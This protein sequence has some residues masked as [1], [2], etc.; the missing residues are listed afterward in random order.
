MAFGMDAGSQPRRPCH[1]GKRRKPV[2][3]MP[4]QAGMAP[5]F[6]GVEHQGAGGAFAP[7]RGDAH[8]PAIEAQRPPDVRQAPAAV[9]RRMHVRGAG[10]G[11]PL[12]DFPPHALPPVADAEGNPSP[13]ALSAADTDAAV[14]TAVLHGIGK[15]VFC[16]VP[17]VERVARGIR[18]AALKREGDV[19][20]GKGG[21]PR[22]DALYEPA[23]VKAFRGGGG[24]LFPGKRGGEY[25]GIRCHL[26]GKF[27]GGSHLH[28]CL[29][30]FPRRDVGGEFFLDMAVGADG[31]LEVMGDRQLPVEHGE[32]GPFPPLLGGE[33]PPVGACQEQ[34]QAREH[35]ACPLPLPEYREGQPEPR[36]QGVC[37]DIAQ[38]ERREGGLPFRLPAS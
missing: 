11:Q 26:P 27:Q 24:V 19:S 25:P 23:E 20:S 10:A 38:L 12:P 14:A 5:P 9:F 33:Q 17:E 2:V 7:A 28:G 18:A 1:H 15:E 29:P 30:R 37:I 34:E 4:W 6:A 32:Q 8:A 16:P 36:F 3:G 13:L 21:M 35:Q 22:D 31:R